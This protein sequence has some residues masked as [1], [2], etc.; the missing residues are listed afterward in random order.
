MESLG[1]M[2]WYRIFSLTIPST[3]IAFI[4][5]AVITGIIIYFKF[6]KET[7]NQFGDLV[8]IFILVWKLSILLTDFS[9]SIKHPWMILYFSGGRTGVYIGVIW[10][11]LSLL[12]RQIQHRSLPSHGALAFAFI[13]F[14]SSF[15]VLVVLLNQAS[16]LDI[17]LALIAAILMVLFI[18]KYRET[19][20]MVLPFLLVYCIF[21]LILRESIFSTSMLTASIFGA[22]LL[23]FRNRFGVSVNNKNTC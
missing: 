12:Y 21:H 1:A 23:L 13:S 9:I 17:V 20:H 15:A 2:E 7:S 10:V 22:V 16:I 3:W 6:N 5:A 14:Y 8:F 18:M 4:L 11:I 19:I